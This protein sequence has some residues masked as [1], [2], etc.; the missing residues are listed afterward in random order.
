VVFFFPFPS[1]QKLVSAVSLITVLSYSIGPVILLHLRKA[2]PD[3]ERP[4]RLRAAGIIAPIAFI[5][6]NWIIY[7]TGYDIGEWM[8]SAVFAY[9]VVYL[10]WC[11]LRGR[12]LRQIGW[13]EG[14][15]VIPYLAGM[16][17]VSYLGPAGAMGG[18]GVIGFFTGMW[19]IAAFSLVILWLALASGQSAEDARQCAERVKTLGS[20][21]T[22][23]RGHVAELEPSP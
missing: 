2:M 19:I 23:S 9:I 11:A 5:A 15:W 4:F 8:F 16:W 3:A 10:V 21:G 13:R 20:C 22:E 14:W 12:S 7:W 17:I 1:W 18:K 6:S